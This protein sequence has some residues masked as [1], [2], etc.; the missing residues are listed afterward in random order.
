MSDQIR[1]AILAAAESRRGMAYR[2]NP[3][4]DGVNNIDCSL[5]V[6]KTVEDAGVPLPPGVRTAEQIR[7]ATVPIANDD[8]LPG[9][10]IYFADTYDA[11]GTPGPD[12]L[13]ASHIGISL[14][15]GTGQMWDANETKGVGITNIRTPY[16]TPKII[17]FGRVPLLAGVVD[18][19]NSAPSTEQPRGIDVSSHQG[20]IDWPAVAQSGIAF[21]FIKVTEDDGYLNPRFEYDWPM[22]RRVGLVRGAYHFA[23]PEGSTPGQQRADATEEADW[24]LDQIKEAGGLLPGDLLALD[25]ESGAGDLGQWALDFLGHCEQRAGF[26]PFVYTGAWFSDPHELDLQTSL[27]A[28]PLWQAAYS[29]TMPA[30]AEPWRTITVWQHS[31]SGQVPGISGAVDLN[32]STVSLDQLRALGKPG[33]APAVPVFVP[34]ATAEQVSGLITAVAYLADNVAAIEDREQRL[35]EARRVREQFI[36][37]KT[38]A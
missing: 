22:A 30:P 25:L 38:A 18:D 9:D 1:D 8:V 16:W 35:A 11:T 26:R 5:F 33:A 7:Q 31:D 19:G 3:P 4:P 37:P 10:L 34:D 20:V 23:R 32:V 29:Q 28:Y 27:A 24:F 14:G 6:L 12:G 17:G 36:G 15:R 21:A 13:I 2:I